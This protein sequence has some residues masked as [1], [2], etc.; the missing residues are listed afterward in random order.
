M[1]LSLISDDDYR[2]CIL[3]AFDDS[4]V[5]RPVSDVK[6]FRPY[7]MPGSESGS[8]R[9]TGLARASEILP[10]IEQQFFIRASRSERKG[11]LHYVP[12]KEIDNVLYVTLT[13]LCV[14]LL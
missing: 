11:G 5:Y 12:Y 14:F 3:E 2:K 13:N 10:A 6:S 9:E 7:F 8:E 4:L 1:Q